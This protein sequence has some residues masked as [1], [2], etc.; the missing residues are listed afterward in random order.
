M[1]TDSTTKP[2][3]PP[4][5][6]PSEPMSLAEAAQLKLLDP[7]KLRFFKNGATLRLT[8]E[9][10]S[11]CLKVNILRVFPLSKP[12]QFFSIRDGANKE[13]G[14]VCDPQ[15]LEPESRKLV[16]AEVERRYLLTV[17]ERIVAVKERFGT[18]EWEVD[19]PRGRTKFT[20]RDLR[21]NV[22][23][24]TPT[25]YLITDVEGNRFDVLNFDELDPA[26]QSL[27]LRHA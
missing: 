15:K 6:K 10:E 18:V 13:V 9:N 24:P 25:R 22:L 27:L 2:A 14:V 5:L 17:I 23:R 20:T 12:A 19:T 3:E 21:E 1:S 4:V 8:I 16:M 26:S 11:S 7:A